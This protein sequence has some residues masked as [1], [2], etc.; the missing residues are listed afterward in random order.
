MLKKMRVP[1]NVLNAKQHEK[2]AEI[3]AEAGHKGRVTIAT[4]MAGRGTD[5]K[6]GEGVVEV[7]GLHILGTERHE[8]RRI[9]N[10]LRGR[11][12]RQGDAGSSRFYLALDDELMRLFGSDRISSLME[13]LGMKEGEPIENAMI[14]RAIENA[15]RRVEGHNFEIRKTLLEYDDVMNQ[16]REVIYTQRRE[17]MTENDPLPMVEGFCDD[18]LDDIYDS[19]AVA[20]KNDPDGEAEQTTRSRLEEVFDFRPL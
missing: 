5:I 1:H 14:T 2:E 15:Q 4:N 3:V 9:D 18:L 6:L 19:L 17:I 20:A 13:R 10:Q 7:G 8:S 12:G 16:Q 11:S